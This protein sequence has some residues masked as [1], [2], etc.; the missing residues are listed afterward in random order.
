MQLPHKA[1]NQTRHRDTHSCRMQ[2]VV[3]STPTSNK[4]ILGVDLLRYE[5]KTRGRCLTTREEEEKA[6]PW[7]HGMS[8]KP[9]PTQT[10]DGRCHGF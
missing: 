7:L 8:K 4:V 3:S 9:A 1:H 2:V 6:T 5:R 10:L